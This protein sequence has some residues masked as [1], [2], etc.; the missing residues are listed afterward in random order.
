MGLFSH[1][2]LEEEEASQFLWWYARQSRCSGTSFLQSSLL[3]EGL[4]DV[5]NTVTICYFITVTFVVVITII[6]NVIIQS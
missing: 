6:I 4:E 5:I 1:F 3:R 2:V